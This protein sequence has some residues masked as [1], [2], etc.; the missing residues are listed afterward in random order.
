MSLNDKD[1]R[2][3]L[4]AYLLTAVSLAWG[5]ESGPEY[6]DN[7]NTDIR[8]TAEG[9]LEIRHDIQYHAHGDEIRRGLF[10]ELPDEVGPLSGFTAR[11]DGVEVEPDLD[12]GA[13]VVAASEPLAVQ[14]IHS[15]QV[16]YLAASP[17]REVAGG[18]SA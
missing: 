6:I 5:H 8:L 9:V 13:I 12:D 3:C 11:I 14:R 16:S 4:L 7:F 15:M 1:I 18:A 10:F 17:L 2:I